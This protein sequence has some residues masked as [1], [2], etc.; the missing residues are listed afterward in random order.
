[1]AKKPRKHVTYA[2]QRERI[3]VPAFGSPLDGIVLEDAVAAVSDRRPGQ[4]GR[5]EFESSG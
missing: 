2:P 4:L 1:M 5:M 3:I